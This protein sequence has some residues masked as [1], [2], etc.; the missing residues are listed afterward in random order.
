MKVIILCGGQGT[1]IRDIS[2]V[3]PKPM[4]TIGG[5]PILWHIMN[6][7]A[8]H[9]LKD[10]VLAL[11]YKGWMIKEYFLNYQPMLSDFTISLSHHGAIEL[12][13]Q[14]SE[15]DWKVTLADTGEQ[16]MTGGRVWRVRK[17][18][19]DDDCFCLTY[20]DAV[21]DLDVTALIRQHRASGLIGTVSAVRVSGRFG[22]L[23]E[24]AGK[25]VSFD[26]KPAVTAGRI[27]GG[28][29][30]FDARR[31]WDYFEDV[32]DLVLEQGP[33]MRMAQDG[34]LGCYSHDGHWQCMDTPREYALLN[35]LWDKGAAFWVTR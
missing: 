29:M 12:H 13:D 7:Y 5:K 16:T 10:F 8:A 3:V 2:E 19:G 32:D 15:A 31:V 9:G 27:N 35:D 34:Q 26:E 14:L 1:R 30:V 21:T 28:F 24:Q 23:Q 17:Y 33:L 20:G 25:I 4:L 11:G 22:E 6:T 18:L